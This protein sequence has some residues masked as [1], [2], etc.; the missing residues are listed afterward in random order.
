MMLMSCDNDTRWDNWYINDLVLIYTL[1]AHTSSGLLEY[2]H[3]FTTNTTVVVAVEK[4]PRLD[5]SC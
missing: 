1:N 4:S 5:F 3:I 2:S